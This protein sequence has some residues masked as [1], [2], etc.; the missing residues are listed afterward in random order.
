[1]TEVTKGTTYKAP[2]IST[3]LVSTLEG[4]FLDAI[5]CPPPGHKSQEWRNYCAQLIGGRL[6]RHLKL[7]YLRLACEKKEIDPESAVITLEHAEQAQYVSLCMLKQ[8][9]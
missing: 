7:D 9:F 4:E 6:F 3:E 5:A 8:R 1:M 2:T